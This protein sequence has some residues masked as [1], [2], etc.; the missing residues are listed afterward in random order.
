VP[1]HPQRFDEV[2]TLLEKRGLRYVRRSAGMPAAA[3]CAFVL[4][5]SMGEMFAYYAACD[6]AFIGGSL[7]PFGGQNLIEACAMG[8]PVLIGPHTWNFEAVANDALQADAALRVADA[9]A[10]GMQ[11][12]ALFADEALRERMSRQALA[13]SGSHRGATQRVMAVIETALP[14]PQG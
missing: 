9:A 11:L 14:P 13:F 5:D 6:V 8:R 7:L 2:A 4:G 12:R 10:L 1:R 3:D